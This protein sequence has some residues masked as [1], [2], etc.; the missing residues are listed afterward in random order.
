MSIIEEALRRAQGSASAG[1]PQTASPQAPKVAP[2]PDTR[3]PAHSW[4]ASPVQDASPGLQPAPLNVVA[5]AILVLTAGLIIGGAF[6]MGRSY[7]TGTAVRRATIQPAADPDAPAARADSPAR[8]TAKRQRQAPAGKA[9]VLSGVVE[10]S[11]EPYA[12]INGEIYAVG[13][14][15]GDAT[16]GAISDGAVTL[17]HDNGRETV[18]R[19]PR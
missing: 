10:G 7:R 14:R 2:A 3:A 4:Q 6:W 13:E 19:V 12:V 11:G 8:K 18:L 16:L 15:I 9:I 1:A 5:L 17:R